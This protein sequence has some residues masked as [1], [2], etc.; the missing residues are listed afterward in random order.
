MSL[1]D[2]SQ[3][4]LVLA[5]TGRDA[6]LAAEVLARAGLQA[7]PCATTAVLCEEIARGAAAAFVAEEA[8]TP[9]AL[10]A[11]ARI[12]EEQ[13]AWSDLPIVVFAHRLGAIDSAPGPAEPLARLGNV[14]LLDR[15][16][17]RRT[18]VSAARAALRV[19]N[20]QYAARAVL[21]RLREALRDRD[22]FLALL[23]H[24]LRNP[25]AALAAAGELL[26]RGVEPERRIA[27]VR[28]QTRQLTRLVDDLLDVSRVTSGKVVL[29]LARVDLRDLVL[30]C[31]ESFAPAA[32]KGGLALTAGTLQEATVD[33]DEVRLDQ[34][35]T[36]L[37]TNAVKYTPHGG[38]VRVEL[39]REGRIAVL[40]VRD[41]GIG[42]APEELGRIFEPFVQV[43]SA[44]DRARG[45]M[46]LGLT[47]VRGL[48]QLHGGSIE[49]LS[50]GP[51]M[52]SEFALRLPLA[53]PSR[54]GNA[55]EARQAEPRADRRDVLVVEDNEDAREALTTML[56]LWGHA[57]RSAA[58]GR[59]AVAL[60]RARRPEVALIDLGL[61]LLDGF[62]VARRLRAE[63]GREPFLVALTGYGQPEDLERTRLAGFDAHL[64]KP[65]DLSRLEALLRA[66]RSETT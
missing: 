17:R 59:E 57:V 27:V 54:S 53:Q 64:T 2:G 6:V 44:L 19:R 14:T 63:H 13:E 24:E 66:L 5:P 29:Q 12:V 51:D 23:G 25:L 55:L 60:A 52:G 49:A 46:G 28:R 48:V 22:R 10:D 3:R 61:P 20:R 34:V 31:L 35:L 4:I 45:G 8:I 39:S 40:R 56:S 18:L 58:D 7:E 1:E 43:S 33:G 42:I 62:E 9:A 37:L 36:N 26:E 30:R 50:G 47:L 16:L 32:A 21:G 41:D 65:T 38:H 15:P 11:L